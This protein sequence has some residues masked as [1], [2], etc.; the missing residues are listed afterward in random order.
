MNYKDKI[1]TNENPMLL[2]TP[3]QTSEYK[4]HVDEKNG[5]EILICTV[6]STVLHYDIRCIEDL[7][8]MLIEYGDWM[9]LG[10]KDEKMEAVPN[11]VEYWARSSSNPIGGWYGLRK[12]FR[13]RFGMYVPPLLEALSLAELTHEKRGNKMKAY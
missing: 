1:G 7:Y 2:R 13:G 3:P 12:G 10:S 8:R 9:E 4:M 11:T 5:K 6:K